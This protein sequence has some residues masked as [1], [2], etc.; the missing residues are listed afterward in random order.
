MNDP[1]VIK[2]GIGNGLGNGIS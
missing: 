1:K 2:F